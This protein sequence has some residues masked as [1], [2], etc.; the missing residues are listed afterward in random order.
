MTGEGR[1]DIITKLPDFKIAPEVSRSKNFTPLPEFR[2][3]TMTE[4]PQYQ[5]PTSTPEMDRLM[6]DILA[7]GKD[8]SPQAVV[9]KVENKLPQETKKSQGFLAQIIEW[10]KT[11]FRNL[12]R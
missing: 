9:K 12:F 1:A 11:T 5:E 7:Q 6:A 4:P 8:S 3:P 2:K 10:F